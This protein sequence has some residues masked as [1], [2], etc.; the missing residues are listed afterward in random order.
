MKPC[1]YCG[2][3]NSAEVTFCQECG[4]EIS[5]RTAETKASQAHELA[6]I[7]RPIGYAS[8][9][10]AALCLYLLSLGPVSYF[11][12]T[13]TPP[14]VPVVT[15]PTGTTMVSVT[16]V[17]TITYPTWVGIV[18]YPAFSMLSL[19]GVGAVYSAYLGWWESR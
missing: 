7:V 13:Q 9:I 8:M 1:A 2:R 18:Y 11:W 19:G 6:W 4:T 10:V 3:E 15:P 5:E 12:A 16:M 14:T 17:S